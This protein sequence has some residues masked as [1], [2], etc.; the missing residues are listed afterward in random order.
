IPDHDLAVTLDAPSRISPGES[1]TLNVTARNMGLNPETS[2]QVQLYINNT[3]VQS[4]TIPTLD[5][6][7]SESMSY[8]WTPSEEGIYNV[9][10]R[11]TPILGE[12]TNLN[13]VATTMVAVRDLH[14]YI[15]IEDIFTWYDAV[16]NGY[17]LFFSGDDIYTT[18]SL[19]FDYPFYDG[20]FDSVALSSNGWLSFGI[21]NPYDLSGP[22]FPSSDPRYAYAIA[23]LWADLIAEAN[24]YI[25]E[26][27]DWF[28]IQFDNYDYL[29][30]ALAGTFQVVFHRSG[31]LSFNYLSTGSPLHGTVG[32]NHGDGIHYNSY[33]IA[34]LAGE[35]AFGLQFYYTLPEHELSL[36]LECLS[37][38][39]PSE[40]V[41]IT[42]TVS[43]IGTSNEYSIELE[44]F[45]DEISTFT[46]TIPILESDE[47]DIHVYHWTVSSLGLHNI[48][49]VISAAPGELTLSNNI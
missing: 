4:M 22:P 29:S 17:Q 8:F 24:I 48:T 20:I 39:N 36:G 47:Q 45:I 18:L 41:D 3:E 31:Q 38:A 30:G 19:P 13:N 21:T 7:S 14:D 44:L 25:W 40:I 37:M 23:P 43:N 35:S 1:T 27:S 2:V 33:P 11:V 9:T 49:A 15:M 16:T 46:T 32:L 42:M 5:A 28:V 10:A 34:D 26:T 6:G 12:D